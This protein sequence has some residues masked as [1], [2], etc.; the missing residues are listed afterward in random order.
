MLSFRKLTTLAVSLYMTS[1]PTVVQAQ[2]RFFPPLTP[3]PPNVH[4]WSQRLIGRVFNF[5]S[6]NR[7][8][9]LSS[10]PVSTRISSP[11]ASVG[12]STVSSQRVVSIFPHHSS[13]RCRVS[14]S[15]TPPS[16]V[17]FTGM[18]FFRIFWDVVLTP[19]RS[20]H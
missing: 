16:L 15:S 19:L 8:T 12:S 6:P 11:R 9:T 4:N 2:V 5:I 1:L 14:R 10:K 17:N 20:L 13:R 7:V 18:L 3:P